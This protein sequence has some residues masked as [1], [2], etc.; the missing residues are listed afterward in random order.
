MVI[1]RGII[2]ICS[3]AID[4]KLF[5]ARE[6]PKLPLAGRLKHFVETY[7]ILFKGFGNFRTCEKIQ[8]TFQQESSP[9]KNSRNTSHESRSKTPGI[10]I[11]RHVG[12][13]SHM[14]NQSFKRGIF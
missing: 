6:V 13:W 7:K 3:A 2:F 14:P 9:T 8:N 1:G 11:N 10:I 12:E 5:S 4:K